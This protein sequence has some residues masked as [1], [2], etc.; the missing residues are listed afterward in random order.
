MTTTQHLTHP[1]GDDPL[2]PVVWAEPIPL[3]RDRGREAIDLFGPLACGAYGKVARIIH[4]R[5]SPGN[6]EMFTVWNMQ[7]PTGQMRPH[8]AGN[9]AKAK[10]IAESFLP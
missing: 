2:G 7:L 8:F 3:S 1:H 5:P 9:L 10:Q 4:K 6:S